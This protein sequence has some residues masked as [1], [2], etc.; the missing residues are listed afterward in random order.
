M[1]DIFIVKDASSIE[2]RVLAHVADDSEMKNVIDKNLDPYISFGARLYR[3]TY[4]DVTKQERQIAK[5][6]TLGCGYQLSGGREEKNKDGDTIKT[7]LWGYAANMGIDM[8]KEQAHDAVRIYRE[9]YVGVTNCWQNLQNAAIKTIQTGERQTTNQVIFG[10]V[11][12][13]KLLYIT[14]P[15]RRRLHYIRP[16]LEHEKTWSGD[17][18]ISITHEGNLQGSKKWDRLKTYGGKLTE[19]IVQAIARDLLLHAM[20]LADKAGL[21]ICGHTHD[22]IIVIADEKDA[23]DVSTE[24]EKCMTTR[25]FWAQD[26]PLAADGYTSQIY[27]KG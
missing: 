12:P 26:L 19:N 5:S 1:S 7:G 8:S 17:E 16:Q 6:A 27:K 20:L 18:R 13:N 21:E 24:L 9:T 11:K 2:Y 22:E 3:K 4:E 15:S 25:P 10:A 23:G 14:L